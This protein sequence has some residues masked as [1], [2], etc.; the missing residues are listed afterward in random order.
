[1]KLHLFVILASVLSTHAFSQDT[2]REDARDALHRS[3]SFFQNKVASPV[4][5]SAVTRP[6]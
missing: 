3:V 6:I 5:T 2:S 4:R 1:M